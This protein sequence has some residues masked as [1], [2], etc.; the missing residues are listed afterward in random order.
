VEE[1]D[2][3]PWADEDDEGNPASPWADEDGAGDSESECDGPVAES[4]SPA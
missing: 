4:D 3:D 1:G 2:A